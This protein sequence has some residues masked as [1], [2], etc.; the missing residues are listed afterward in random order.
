MPHS[1]AV[2]PESEEGISKLLNVAY[3]DPTHWA[4]NQQKD[5]TLFFEY[6]QCSPQTFGHL[7]LQGALFKSQRHE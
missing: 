7:T 5:F 3:T 4:R 6:R 2:L 1:Y